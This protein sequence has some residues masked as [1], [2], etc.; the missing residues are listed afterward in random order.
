MTTQQE[1]ILKPKLG[2]LELAR[3]LGNVSQAC[4]IMGYSRDT[5]WRNKAIYQNGGK[6]PLYLRRHHQG[7]GPDIPADLHRYLQPGLHRQALHRQEL[8]HLGGPAQR[9]GGCFL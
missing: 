9:P 8:H 6:T 1:K 3:Q 5:F 2:L 4:Q 7:S